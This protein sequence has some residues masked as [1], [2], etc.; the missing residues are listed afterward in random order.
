MD[1][2][3]SG[4]SGSSVALAETRSGGDGL[5]VTE[6]TVRFGGILAL[7]RVD[8]IARRG[9]I[10]GLIGPNGAGKTTLFNCLT[11]LYRATSGRIRW[12]DVE[13]LG[14]QPYQVA[15]HGISR[16]FQ[17]LALFPRLTVRQNVIV[18]MHRVRRTDWVSNALRMPWVR[19]EEREIAAR[20]TAA[21]DEVGLGDVADR[22][23]AGLPYGTLKRVELARAVASEPSLL[24][25][26]EPAAGLSHSEVDELM[27]VV[28][29][30]RDRYDL[31]IVLVEH[32]MGLVMRL[33]DHLTVLNFGRTIATGSPAEV[34]S[35]P[36]VIE[37]YLG[38]GE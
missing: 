2:L 30:L 16:T 26:D 37:A 31:T 4:T 13:L 8:M 28:R 22:P 21:L 19:K 25:L 29:L 36:A 38:G 9:E 14:M 5:T 15:G 24:L 27:D 35:N 18:G 7:D 17:N 11:G 23:A 12:N 34:R 1:D 32:H 10:S 33:C 20:A 3:G 6:V